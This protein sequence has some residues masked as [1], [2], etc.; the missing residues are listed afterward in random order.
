MRIGRFIEHDHVQYGENGKTAVLSPSSG[1]S[2]R[3]YSA[4]LHNRSGA[5][6]DLALAR[7]FPS[8]IV[9]VTAT[10]TG[11]FL[12]QCP[13]KFGMIGLTLTTAAT[14]GTTY[15]LEYYNGSGYTALTAISASSL[16]STGDKLFVFATPLDMALNGSNY[17]V[18]IVPNADPATDPVASTSFVARVIHFQAAVQ[19]NGVMAVNFPYEKPLLLGS[20][21]SL[22]P[23][24]AT[25]SDDNCV[26]LVYMQ[27][28]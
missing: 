22:L 25:S 12:V 5:S 13:Q 10:G 17:E 3:I 4:H 7:K 26:S 9:D 23:F 18:R 1:K 20:G 21:E 2:L 27:G 11:G 6:A 28:D 14:G 8:S 15:T 24:F 16:T 19:N